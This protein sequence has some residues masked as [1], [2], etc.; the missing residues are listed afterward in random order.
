MVM[1]DGDYSMV[2]I[3]QGWCDDEK[4]MQRTWCIKK[5]R[6]PLRDKDVRFYSELYDESWVGNE[7]WTSWDQ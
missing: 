7:W 2:V 4:Y 6:S 5:D 3:Y 1:C